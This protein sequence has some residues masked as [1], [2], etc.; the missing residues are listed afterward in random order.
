LCNYGT[1]EPNGPLADIVILDLYVLREMI[2]R[3]SSKVTYLKCLTHSG[4]DIDEELVISSHGLLR[5]SKN[6][7]IGRAS[8]SV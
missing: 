6:S 8:A 2:S 5:K 1:F 4:E 3:I 7:L